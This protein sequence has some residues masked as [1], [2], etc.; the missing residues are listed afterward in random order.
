MVP[1]LS[2]A[3]TKP[4]YS[5]LEI[6]WETSLQ[7]KIQTLNSLIETLKMNNVIGTTVTSASFC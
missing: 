1:F 6:F 5:L 4:V 2:V 3:E 7:G